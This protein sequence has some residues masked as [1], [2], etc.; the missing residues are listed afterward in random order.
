MILLLSL[1]CSAP[2]E[3]PEDFNELLSYLFEHTMNDDDTLIAGANNLLDFAATNDEML[4]EGYAVDNLSQMALDS[5]GETFP[6]SEDTYGV[7]LQYSVGYSIEN[8]AYANTAADGMEVYPANY[9][10]YERENLTDVNCFLEKTC[11]SFSYRSTILSSLPLGAEM[12]SSYISDIRWIDLDSPRAGTPVLDGWRS[13]KQCR[14]GRH[15]RQLLSWIHL[16]YRSRYRHHLAASCT[17][18]S[19]WRCIFAG[20]HLKEPSHRWTPPKWGGPRGLV[21]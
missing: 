14:L 13:R 2:V 5:T 20:R 1:A 6:T 21:R 15:D 16:Q 19:A 3:A 17:R 11:I 8:L 18:H 4:R 10:S 12:L 7:T 9:L